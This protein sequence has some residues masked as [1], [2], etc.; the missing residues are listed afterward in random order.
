MHNDPAASWPPIEHLEIKHMLQGAE[1]LSVAELVTL[2]QA[3]QRQRW[4]VGDRV[5][6]EVYLNY[7][8]ALRDNSDAVLPLLFF[9]AGLR[10]ADGA[11]PTADDLVRRFPQFEEPIRQQYAREPTLHS[12]ARN[13]NA[14]TIDYPKGEVPFEAQ[15]TLGVDQAELRVSVVRAS[16]PG[17]EIVSELGRGGMGVVYK[18][19]HLA[20][21]R[22][23]ALK[24]I[25]SGAHAGADELARFRNE[26][27]AVARVQ[28][29]NLVQIYEVG[30]HEGRP[31]FALEYVDGQALDFRLRAGQLEPNEAA[32]LLEIL[33]RAV[34]A[35]HQHGLVHRDLKPA[36][37]LMTSTGVPKITDFG[38]AKRLDSTLGKTVTGDV[39]GTPMYMSPEQASGRVKQIGPA[40]DIYALG[41]ILYEMLTGRPP[42][43]ANSGIDVVMMVANTEPQPP[44]KIRLKLPRDLETICMK[45]LEKNPAR[46]YASA[47]EL[48][49]DL[50]RFQA[51]EPIKARPIGAVGL[52]LKWTRRHP[53]WA[54]LFAVIVL[55][56]LVLLG[57]GVSYHIH[58][59]EAL[60]EARDKGEESRVR[61]VRL[62]E[63]QESLQKALQEARDKGEESRQRLVRLNVAQGSTL[64]DAGDWYGALV[65]FAEA[66]R[67]DQGNPQR[68]AMHRLRL[69]SVLHLC[70]EVRH[71]WFHDKAINHVAFSPD[72]KQ[73][74][75]AS[76][77]HTARLWD[78]ATGKPVG[79]A[80]THDDAVVHAAFSYDGQWVL[81]ASSDG[82]A[83]VWNAATGQPR[84]PPLRH[85]KP[86][87][88]AAFSPD[89]TRV[90]TCGQDERA[91]LW[92]AASGA[93]LPI[94]LAHFGPINSVAFSPDGRWIATASEDL[95]ARIWHADT[96]KPGPAVSHTEALL[97]VCFRP[98][99]LVF[100]TTSMDGTAQLW[101]TATGEAVGP[102][103]VHNRAV[104]Q[105]SF[106]ID[107]KRVATSSDD[108]TARI[109]DAFTGQRL[110]P[111]VKHTSDVNMAVFSPDGQWLLTGG[112]DNTMRLW[113]V[114]SAE[115]VMPVFFF[116]GSVE[117][118]AFSPSGLAMLAAGRG[119]MARL[120]GPRVEHL[121]L[122]AVRDQKQGKLNKVPPA[123]QSSAT[124]HNGKLLLQANNDNSATLHEASTGQVVGTP[125]HHGSKVVHVA[126]SPDDRHLLTGSDDNTARLWDTATGQLLVPPLKHH[127]TVVY[128]AFSADG[129]L[130]VTASRDETARVWDAATGEPVTPP[131]VHA[132]DVGHAAIAADGL[133]VTTTDIDG[134]KYT[135][136]L[137]RD[138]RP[139]EQIVEQAQLLAGNYLDAT[140][141][142]LPLPMGKM[143]DMYRK[144][145]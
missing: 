41:T 55:G 64:L 135:W 7:V 78:V 22:L 46:R 19:R 56:T 106:S 138:D 105:A 33:A 132:G 74:L 31:Y 67:L 73:A 82:T 86:L 125:L 57:V 36:N 142:Y 144:Q 95:T 112:D 51:G 43:R 127:G 54:T 17:Y 20:L 63:A 42:F 123:S 93:Q 79:A 25:L 2:L 65:F 85:G 9:E 13:R 40:T 109:W 70:P 26:A 23:V 37:I 49:D 62:N 92:D 53:A 97:W 113:N 8:P 115:E 75:T 76:D 124:S 69:G 119:G 50:Q 108:H 27:E 111:P 122:L 30:E 129:R 117:T 84:T 99:S 39:L 60:Q 126:F 118:V 130:V 72:G 52:L 102:P 5:P 38:L 68:E 29:P 101:K 6:V 21:N 83:R 14:E 143:Q 100:V 139:V 34:H 10:E 88:D 32:R 3:D 45:C 1:R 24:M 107:G 61:L 59:Q 81:T 116:T 120:I 28:H 90:A 35:V 44:S 89:G 103:L 94:A 47:L 104:V 48:A 134:R 16:V 15:R 87:Y 141:G 140:R 4:Q 131:L 98:D 114:A 137:V 128:A 145:R 18:A 71:V 80:L 110:S 96:G 133:T 66:L 58:L 136:K 11:V 121:H 77:D 12:T 91:L